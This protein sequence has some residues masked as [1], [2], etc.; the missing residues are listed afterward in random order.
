MYREEHKWFEFRFAF[1]LLVHRCKL[2][3]LRGHKV[4]AVISYL[5]FTVY[6][7]S[8]SFIHC[9]FLGRTKRLLSRAAVVHLNFRAGSAFPVPVCSVS[10]GN[11]VNKADT[12]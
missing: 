10:P 8:E 11:W 4:V 12:Q 2:Q 5:L 6:T 9:K 3:G 7:C 1:L